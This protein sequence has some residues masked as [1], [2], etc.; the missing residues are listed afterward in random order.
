MPPNRWFHQ[1]FNVGDAPG[2]YL[3]LHPPG[4]WLNSEQIADPS[5]DQIE[6]PDEEAFI[7]NYFAEQLEKRGL[8][9][10]M[11]DEAYKDRDFEWDY[12][13]MSGA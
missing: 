2:R 1:H 13:H 4:Q 5:R 12:S 8:R 10:L 6:Y 7:R 11:P 9:S 3:A